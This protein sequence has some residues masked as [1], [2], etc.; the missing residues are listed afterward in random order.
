MREMTDVLAIIVML[1][2]VEFAAGRTFIVDQSLL[3][4]LCSTRWCNFKKKNF[5]SIHP[6]LIDHDN[7]REISMGKWIV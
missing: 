4:S 6:S 7:S 3:K 2:F 1:V 5:C